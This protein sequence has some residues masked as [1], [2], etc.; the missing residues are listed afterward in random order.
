MSER[1]TVENICNTKINKL[2]DCEHFA[3]YVVKKKQQK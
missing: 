1:I 2:I 3:R